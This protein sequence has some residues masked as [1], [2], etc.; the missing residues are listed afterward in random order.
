MALD[1]G[2]L[3]MSEDP[4][5]DRAENGKTALGVYVNSHYTVE[6]APHVGFDWVFIDQMFTDIGWRQT[7]HMIRAAEAAG[8]TPVVRVQST[9]WLGYDH[10]VAI[11]VARNLGI[12]RSTS[13]SRT[14]AR[15]NSRNACSSPIPGNGRRSTS[16][17]SMARA[18]GPRTSAS[19]RTAPTSFP[20]RRRSRP[21]RASRRQCANR[22]STT[23]SS[24]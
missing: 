22:R 23:C 1:S 12:G 9:P 8:I 3:R 11:D 2:P 7:G 15:G 24:Q 19:W 6:L 17:R 13:W 5:E 4:L 18:S 10:H 21:S 14:P 20:S 16:T